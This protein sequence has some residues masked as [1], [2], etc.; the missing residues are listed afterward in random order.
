MKKAL[1]VVLM[2]AYQVAAASSLEGVYKVVTGCNPNNSR[3]GVLQLM[4][5]KGAEVNIE[6]DQKNELL[7]FSGYHTDTLALPL[8]P[9]TQLRPLYFK[10]YYKNASIQVTNNS[11]FL[12]TKGSELGMCDNY[13]FPGSRPCLSKWNDGLALQVNDAGTLNIDWKIEGATGSCSLQRQR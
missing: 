2:L 9:E 6:L 10:N 13:P 4:Y 1:F 3:L 11:Y 12:K 5:D 8:F 7:L